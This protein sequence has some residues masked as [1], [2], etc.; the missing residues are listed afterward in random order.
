MSLAHHPGFVKLQADFYGKDKEKDD[1]ALAFEPVELLSA[2]NVVF[3]NYD[4]YCCALLYE[5]PK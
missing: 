1:F 4:D 2:G 5:Y 3:F